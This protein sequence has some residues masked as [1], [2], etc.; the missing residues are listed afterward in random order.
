MNIIHTES[1]IEELCALQGCRVTGPATYA[2][3]TGDLRHFAVA[4][5]T[6]CG[7]DGIMN[8]LV[9]SREPITESDKSTAL[10]DWNNGR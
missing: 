10:R 9:V 8:H 5:Q 6:R 3:P 2:L 4:G 7:I 1:S